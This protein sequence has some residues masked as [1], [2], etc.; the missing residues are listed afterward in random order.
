MSPFVNLFAKKQQFYYT[1]SKLCVNHKIFDQQP[2]CCLHPW[3]ED[4]LYTLSNF[5]RVPK[6]SL[7]KSF[8]VTRKSRLCSSNVFNIFDVKASSILGLNIHFEGLKVLL[9]W[10]KFPLLIT[11][12]RTNCWLAFTRYHFPITCS[13]SK[14]TP[15]KLAG[16]FVHFEAV[17][18]NHVEPYISCTNFTNE[19]GNSPMFLHFCIAFLCKGRLHLLKFHLKVVVVSPNWNC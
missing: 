14:T 11:L 7:M 12:A 15:T 5:V 16:N 6:F 13:L 3:M 1:L 2:S 8:L 9:C 17:L 18:F 10:L 4:S 19:E